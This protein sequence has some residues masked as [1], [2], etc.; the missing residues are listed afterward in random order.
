MNSKKYKPVTY[1]DRASRPSGDISAL[2]T[3][4]ECPDREATAPEPGLPEA[5]VRT[6]CRIRRLSSDAERRSLCNR[7]VDTSVNKSQAYFESG[8]I[9]AD[10]EGMDECLPENL[11]TRRMSAQS[12][13][14]RCTSTSERSTQDRKCKFDQTQLIAQLEIHLDSINKR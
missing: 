13:H 7:V 8:H 10:I 6:S 3:Q 12:L 4:E 2:R 1:P 14:G 9:G 5:E 11:V